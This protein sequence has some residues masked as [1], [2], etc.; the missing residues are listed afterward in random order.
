MKDLKGTKTEQCL[1][2][3]FAGESQAVVKYTIF[4]KEAQKQDFEQIADIFR[5]TAGNELTHAKIWLKRLHPDNKVPDTTPNL[6]TAIAGENYEHTTMYENFAKT[7]EEEGFTEIAAEFRRVG[8]VEADHE[9]RYQT[10]LDNIDD[11][12]VFERDKEVLWQCRECGHIQK[13]KSAPAKCPVC[14]HPRGFFQLK[15]ENF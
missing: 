12:K 8:A 6:K 14:G 5:I 13:G 15:Q 11:G 1:K 3:A 2:D 7:A 4:A 10:L 9:A